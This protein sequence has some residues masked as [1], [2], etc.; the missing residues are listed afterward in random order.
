MSMLSLASSS[1]S[2]PLA[3]SFGL[4]F[5][6]PL[7]RVVVVVVENREGEIGKLNEHKE[8]KASV[9][10]VRDYLDLSFTL[11]LFH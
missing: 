10:E 3:S 1:S 4:S 11:S 6:H 8:T 9:D 7:S 2:F 5:P